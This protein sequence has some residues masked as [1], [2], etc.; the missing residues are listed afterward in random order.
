[1]RAT[2]FIKIAD[3]ASFMRDLGEPIGWGSNYSE[4]GK[5]EEFVKKLNLPIY[6]E[7]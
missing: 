6:N 5:R 1:M 3:F 2:G 7:F 4:D